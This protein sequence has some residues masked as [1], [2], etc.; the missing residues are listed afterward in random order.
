MIMRLFIFIAFFSI[1]QLGY[2]VADREIAAKQAA[3][4]WL[5]LVDEGKYERAL[6][7]TDSA[8]RDRIQLKDWVAG[9]SK[10]RTPLGSVRKRN[11]QRLFATPVLPDAPEGDYVVVNFRTVFEGREEPAD[12]IVIMAA[13]L[14]ADGTDDW[15]V[16][17]YY[18]N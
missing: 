2:A 4:A 14:K 9:L 7:K 8:L 5:P 16:V 13:S 18:I 1:C 12:E 10:A 3:S 17:G 11:L 15:Q 6:E